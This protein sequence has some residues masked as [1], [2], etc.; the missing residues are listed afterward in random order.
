MYHA[1]AF[2]LLLWKGP[3]AR[4]K[5]S[6]SN[7]RTVLPNPQMPRPGLRPKLS[8]VVC[9][10]DL[11][12]VGS[13]VKSRPSHTHQPAKPQLVSIHLLPTK[14]NP[15]AKARSLKRLRKREPSGP[16]GRKQHPLSRR[17]TGIQPGRKRGH[18]MLRILSGQKLHR[19]GLAATKQGR[20]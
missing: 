20:L 15:R 4:S 19:L 7:P 10:S 1:T 6:G 12:Q 9:R 3:P 16:R 13:N 17:P 14:K 18:E 11:R 8:N 2:Q 5:D